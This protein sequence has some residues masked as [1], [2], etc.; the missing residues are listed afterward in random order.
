MLAVNHSIQILT[1]GSREK[2]IKLSDIYD[3]FCF[4]DENRLNR[5]KTQPILFVSLVLM[6]Q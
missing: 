3:P 4:R 5:G 1:A 6:E 2:R